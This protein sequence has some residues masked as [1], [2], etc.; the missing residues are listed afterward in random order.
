[1][2]KNS[3]VI[4]LRAIRPLAVSVALALSATSGAIGCARDDSDAIRATGGVAVTPPTPA[5]S[6]VEVDSL[7]RRNNDPVLRR[8]IDSAVMALPRGALRARPDAEIKRAWHLAT[9]FSSGNNAEVRWSSAVIDETRRRGLT[10]WFESPETG[11]GAAVAGRTTVAVPPYTVIERVTVTEIWIDV[12]IPSLHPDL[13]SRKLEAIA[14]AIAARERATSLAMYRT[15]QAFKANYDAQYEAKHPGV[16]KRG[17]LGT[18]R[19]GAW[20]PPLR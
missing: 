9:A 6:Q 16:I 3:F 20:E 19:G 1:M 2:A 12:L 8:S 4:R 15:R 14:R 11:Q 10:P 13:P 18:M 7:A 17:Y 5:I